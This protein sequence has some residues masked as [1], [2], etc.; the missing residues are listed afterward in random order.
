MLAWR[1]IRQ[2]DGQ[3]IVNWPSVPER[4]GA[5]RE[6]YSPS[7]I[8]D[9]VEFYGNGDQSL[10]FVE[11]RLI[12]FPEDGRDLSSE[13]FAAS[14][15]D[16][17]SREVF[18]NSTAPFYQRGTANLLFE[19]ERGKRGIFTSDLAELFDTIPHNPRILTALA[20]FHNRT[21]LEP[22]SY[23][24]LHYRR[25][26][27]YD[28]LRRDLPQHGGGSIDEKRI[29]FL[30]SHFVVRTAPEDY[31]REE[32]ERHLEAGKRIVFTSDSPETI[33]TFQT[34]YGPRNFVDLSSFTLPVPIQKAFFDFL[35]I[36]NAA[37]ILG[38]SSNFSKFASDLGGGTFFNATCGGEIEAL[39]AEFEREILE[40][41][42]VETDVA[43]V[44]LAALTDHYTV[45][46]K[47]VQRAG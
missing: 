17:F 39:R 27:C 38:T 47:R 26:D 6:N 33:E 42:T 40:R 44:A 20:N 29:R 3:L 43:R 13:E 12:S 35:V 5:E 21:G 46:R 32:L 4:Y 15:K 18:L 45:I 25:G 30:V 37:A 16:G 10:L 34:N 24:A 2:V 9:L 36:K 11:Q 41:A 31:F 19:G 28:M 22:G 23:V 1:F 7:E 8:F 14:L